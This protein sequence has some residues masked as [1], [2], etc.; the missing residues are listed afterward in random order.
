M[1]L[2]SS[3][4]GTSIYEQLAHSLGGIFTINTEAEP[5][6]KIYMKIPRG[7]EVPRTS[8]VSYTLKLHRN[9]YGGTALSQ[10]WIEHMSK[11]F[12]NKGFKPSLIE[13]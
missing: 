1:V 11:G 8:N 12:C 9:I 5:Q 4:L 13:Y 7:T 10:I 6:C 2:N 3:T